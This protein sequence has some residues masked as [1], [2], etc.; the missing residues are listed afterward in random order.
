MH[1]H[2]TRMAPLLTHPL[3]IANGVTAVRDMGGCIGMEDAF[4]GCALKTSTNGAGRRP[5]AR[6]SA[7]DYDQVT[8]LAIN[9]GRAIPSG[10]DPALGASTPERSKRQRVAL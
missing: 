7:R 5:P 2:S 10:V 3:F 1:M 8:S 9:G 4:V 6:W